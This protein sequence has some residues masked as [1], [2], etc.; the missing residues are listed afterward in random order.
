MAI[1]KF[2][3]ISANELVL[4]EMGVNL[5]WW[6]FSFLNSLVSRWWDLSSLILEKSCLYSKV[7]T[8]LIDPSGTGKGMLESFPREKI[9]RYCRRK[10]LSMAVSKEMSLL[11][12][13]WCCVKGAKL[14]TCLDRIVL[15]L[16]PLKKILECL[17]LSR[18][19]LF[20]R[21]KKPYTAWSFCRDSPLRWV[22]AT[23]LWEIV[24]GKFL[25]G[26][27]I[28]DQTQSHALILI[29]IM[30]MTLRLWLFRRN[31]FPC[32][33][34][35]LYPRFLK[36]SPIWERLLHLSQIKLYLRMITKYLS[37]PPIVL[38]IRK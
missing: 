13:R 5:F 15:W 3:L 12:K 31:P 26:I 27:R 19:I 2:V 30:S 28:L 38:M 6:L 37:L 32:V 7:E 36:I 10:F 23:T 34:R 16:H 20:H 25:V 8:N 14:D 18:V 4:Y 21:I 33:Q 9:R 24:P 29:H 11:R 35:K 17:P 1:L 22:L